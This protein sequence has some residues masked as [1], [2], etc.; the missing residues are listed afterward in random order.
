[1]EKITYGFYG[2][3]LGKMVL[4]Q[5]GHGLCWLGFMVEGYKGNGYDRMI[6]HF[7]GAEFVRSDAAMKRIGDTI[8]RAWREGEEPRISLDLRGTSFQKS[9]WQSLL[10]IRKGDV[11]TYADIANDIGRPK[12]SRA[13]GSAVGT[14]PV[15]LVVPCHRVVQKSGN[16]GNFGWG[17]DLKRDILNAE[18]APIDL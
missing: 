15:S 18:D 8:L 6:K 11:K 12:A 14:N 16:I 3:P 9:V 2:S 4:A 17:V 1:M 5:S 13:V 7:P 10:R